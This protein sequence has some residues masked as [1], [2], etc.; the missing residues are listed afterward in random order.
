MMLTF[1]FCTFNR[2]SRISRLV[3][4]MRAQECPVPF[5]I[6]A[7]NNN[8]T[9]NTVEVLTAQAAQPGA[10]LRFVTETQQGIVPA[11]NRAIEEAIG[12]DILVFID[13]DELPV[14]GLLRAAHSAIAAEGAQCAGGRI[15]I[16]LGENERPA[17]LDDEI[18]GFLGELDHGASPFWIE[19]ASRPVWCG[20]IAYD[21]RIFRENPQ[22]RF[23]LRYNRAG[24]GIGGGEDAMMFRTLLAQGA[25]IRYRP[26]MRVLH[27]VDD[28]KLKRSYFLRLHYLAGVRQGRYR[29][30]S[31]DRTLFDVPPFLVVQFFRQAMRSIGMQI[32]QRPGS[33]R[34]AMNAI[35]TLG[36]L[37]GYRQRT[38][39]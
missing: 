37:V 17:W 25:R 23:D 18:A 5:E 29:L 6:L 30:P 21:M 1:A 39:S 19:D 24:D 16:D 32:T 34:Q 11:R 2:A 33:L 36:C 8:S 26:D 38:R 35:N 13:D 20:N 4:S 12:S 27:A 15:T 10:P 3:E 28:W 22:L 9:D 31:Y 14:A 7:I